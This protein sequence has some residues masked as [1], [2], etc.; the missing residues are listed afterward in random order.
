MGGDG[1]LSP[2]IDPLGW[3]MGGVSAEML[4]GG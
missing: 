3:S 2:T 1:Y 4:E